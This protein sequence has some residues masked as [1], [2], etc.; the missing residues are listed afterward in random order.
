MNFKYTILLFVLLFTS[1]IFA[2]EKKVLVEIFTN[3]HCGACP[4]AHS[5]LDQYLQ[6]ENGNKIEFIFYHMAFPYSSDELYKHNKSDSE[7]KSNFYGSFSSTPQPFF[8]GV[9][10]SRNYSQWSSELD[11]LILQQSSFELEVNG[12]RNGAN[13][14]ISA[15]VTKTSDVVENDLTINYVIVEHIDNYI[16]GNNISDHKNVMRKIV[17]PVG[18]AFEINLNETKELGATINFNNKWVVDELKIIVFIQSTSTKK[19]YQSSSISYNELG[20]TGVNEENNIPIKFGLEQ[21]YPNPFNPTTTIKYSIPF[22]VR[23]VVSK[24][25]VNNRL[26]ESNYNTTLKVYDILGKEVATLVNKEQVTGNYEVEFDA[27]KLSSGIYYY[28]LIAGNF[29]TTKKL[30]LMK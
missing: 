4:P 10:K 27:S 30:V 28:T 5:A 24:K 19:I 23:N 18:D 14:T 13:F 21:N 11:A 8:D 3:A 25:S 9:Y 2:S 29:S 7:N 17:N 26:V 15:A 16:G 12:S 20:V 6:S 1:T 22:V